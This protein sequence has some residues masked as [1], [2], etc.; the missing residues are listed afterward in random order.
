MQNNWI[1]KKLQ[2]IILRAALLTIYKSF[3][4]PHL[5]CGNIIY[6]R[7]FNESFQNKLQSVLYNAALAITRA[8]TC[9]R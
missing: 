9:L 5:D 4:R 8:I 7:E 2:P 3:Y 6:D 1:D